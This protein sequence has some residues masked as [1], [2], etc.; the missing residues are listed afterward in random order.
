M[1]QYVINLKN[2]SCALAK[3]VHSA[4]FGWNVLQISV[5]FIWSN[6]SF[7]A[8]VSLLTFYLDDLSISVSGGVK[9]LHYHFQLVTS[10]KI[11][12]VLSLQN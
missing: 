5:R 3:K 9:V 12:I 11:S 2:V 1:T 8:C 7:K 10:L 4:A 6:M